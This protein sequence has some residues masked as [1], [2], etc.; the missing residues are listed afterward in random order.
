MQIIIR[1]NNNISKSPGRESHRVIVIFEGG[2]PGTNGH[3]VIIKKAHS[4]NCEW[5]RINESRIDTQ[6]GIYIL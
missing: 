2:H 6:L 1:S 5:A 3:I 4:L